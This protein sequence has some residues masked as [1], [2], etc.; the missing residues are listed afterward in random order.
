MLLRAC[1]ISEQAIDRFVVAGAFGTYLDLQSA[2]QIGMFPPLPLERFEQVGNAAG[3]GA[4]YLLLSQNKRV[5][6]ND[7]L[8]QV[9]YVELTA[10]PEFS[11]IYVD[12]LLFPENQ[13]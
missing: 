4:K 6:V 11:D 1:G 7:I 12:A 3:V 2:V 10:H 13:P 8:K 5:H 9:E